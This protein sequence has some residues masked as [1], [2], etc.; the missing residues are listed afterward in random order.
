[1]KVVGFLLLV[2]GWFLVLAALDLLRSPSALAAFVIA[3][4]AIEVLGLVLVFRARLEQA[5]VGS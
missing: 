3:G 1:M 2:T 4:V 5:E